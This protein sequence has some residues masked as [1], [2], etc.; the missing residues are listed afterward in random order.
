MGR[1]AAEGTCRSGGRTAKTRRDQTRICPLSGER[2][3]GPYFTPDAKLKARHMKRRSIKKFKKRHK[4][5][6]SIGVILVFL[7]KQSREPERRRLT[8]IT[9]SNL[10][11][12]LT[13]DTRK[14]VNGKATDWKKTFVRVL[15]TQTVSVPSGGLP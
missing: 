3:V 12:H 5:E 8:D 9:A 14:K 10:K 15:D 1:R 4:E 2:E 11:L 13:S 6:E 7:R